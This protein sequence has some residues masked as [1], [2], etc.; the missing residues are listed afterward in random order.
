MTALRE[1]LESSWSLYLTNTG[2]QS[3]FQ[4]HLPML[5]C[6]PSIFLVTFPL[7]F[8][9]EKRYIEKYEYPDGRVGSCESVTTL[10]EELLRILATISA[11]D[12]TTTQ[13]NPKK[14]PK[15][16][17]V[18]THK[19]LLPEE[20]TIKDIDEQLK[21]HVKHTILF[22]EHAIQFNTLEQ[23]I[24]AVNNLSI[25]D[26]DFKTIRSAIQKT[27]ES[28]KHSEQF[29]I[30][31][32]TS[33]LVF[34]IVLR[35]KHKS[36]DRVLSFDECFEIAQNCGILNRGELAQALSFIHSRLGLVRY[37]NVEE[38]DKFVII[39]PQIIFDMITKLIVAT[40]SGDYA[41]QGE[42]EDFQ[43]GIVPIAVV[44]RIS[45]ECT[46]D[47]KVPFTWLM[48]LLNYLK[49]AALFTDHSGIDKYF[50]PSVI[51]QVS[52]PI[53]QQA[54]PSKSPLAPDLLVGFKNGFCPRGLLGALVKY[55]MTNEM[56]SQK[57]WR[58]DP[59][60]I[61]T[62]Q[63]SFCIRPY[64]SITLKMFPT[65]LEVFLNSEEGH[66]ARVTCEEAFVQ[67]KKGMK[68]I[69]NEYIKCKHFFGFYCTLNH[70]C[71]IRPHPARVYWQKES[72]E[73]AC[74]LKHLK[75]SG[76]SKSLPKG[77]DMWNMKGKKQGKH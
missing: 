27:V 17:F 56:K 30:T 40:F 57:R 60:Q 19:D 31:C 71:E 59:D 33:W 61:F 48:K 12:Y 36:K 52:K 43:K 9:L 63:V 21:N 16:F 70:E 69:T 67:I 62:N 14:V 58:L 23:M 45:K 32:C 28:K 34:S 13:C 20:K 73:L 55:L 22:K 77:Y 1:Q 64:G 42:I 54:Y 75:K 26:D 39:D 53:L 47:I 41:E 29:K 2:G 7:H 37:F 10:I 18:G 76:V 5:V 51:S 8:D 4:E 11:L 66:D 49:V 68:A 3:V 15:V 65:H 6:G 46:L 24:F 25:D 50:F 35:A 72:P 44:E 38:L 74:T